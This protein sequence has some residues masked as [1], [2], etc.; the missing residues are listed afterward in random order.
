MGNTLTKSQFD[1]IIRDN[2][3]KHSGLKSSPFFEAKDGEHAY[4]NYYIDTAFGEFCD[5]MKTNYPKAY[6]AYKYGPGKEMDKRLPAPA[7]MASVA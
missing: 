1:T 5:N 6:E 4:T 3:L 7:K 2:I